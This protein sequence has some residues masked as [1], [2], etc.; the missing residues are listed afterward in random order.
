MKESFFQL[1]EQ[2]IT[3]VEFIKNNLCN[4]HNFKL[5]F[6]HNI[7]VTNINE[8]EA[9]VSLEFS[10]FNKKLTEKIP[11]YINIKI[12]GI[13]IWKE[14]N[15]E[16]LLNSLLYENA[17]AVLLSFIRSMI[18]QITAYSGYPTLIIPLLNF[19]KD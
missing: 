8:R 6:K 11:F 12:E 7:K 16:D 5:E 15:D 18:S 1:K 14:I 4:E 10:V 19:K 2:N 17:P 13:F 3:N 9:V